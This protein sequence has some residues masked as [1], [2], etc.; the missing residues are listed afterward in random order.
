MDDKTIRDYL[1]SGRALKQKFEEIKFGKL[2]KRIQLEER[3][4]PITESLQTL[5]ENVT[6]SIQVQGDK[7]IPFI[8]NDL[9]KPGKNI[10]KHFGV[11]IENR[12]LFVGNSQLTI[13]PDN[14]VLLESDQSLYKG[15][16]GLWELLTAENPQHYDA[17]DLS[18]YEQIVLRSYAYRRKN[19]RHSPYYKATNTNKYR[20]LIRPMLVKYHIIKQQQPLSVIK[21][22]ETDDDDDEFYDTS[23][24]EDEDLK[25]GSGLRKF[26]TGQPVE[27]VHWNTVD[28]LVERLCHLWGEIQSGNTNPILLNEV[29]NIIQEFKEL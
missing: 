14:N 16:P 6:K 9:L 24:Y 26:N 23:F 10:D 29:V 27:Y 21:E 2:T 7:G 11:R 4:K 28:E 25:K 12:G 1:E 5:N 22:T 13:T 3:F 18:N 15:T 17:R 8:L 19:D 20:T